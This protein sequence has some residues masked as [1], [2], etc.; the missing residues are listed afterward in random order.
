MPS[1]QIETDW[2]PNAATVAAPAVAAVLLL[3]PDLTAPGAPPVPVSHVD[4]SA[5]ARL[6][7]SSDTDPGGRGKVTGVRFVIVADR[8]LRRSRPSEPCHGQRERPGATGAPMDG[9]G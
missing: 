5:R 6:P 2:M 4:P 9:Q 1:G 7:T 3:R 8:P